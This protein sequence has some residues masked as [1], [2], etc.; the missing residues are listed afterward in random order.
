MEEGFDRYTF[1][2]AELSGKVDYC[3]FGKVTRDFLHGFRQSKHYEVMLSAFLHR[4]FEEPEL[5]SPANLKSLEN[6]LVDRANAILS[7]ERAKDKDRL[8]KGRKPVYELQE[9]EES[10]EEEPVLTEEELRRQEEERLERELR[11]EERL[12]ARE[13]ERRRNEEAL[14]ARARQVDTKAMEE[15][16][17]NAVVLNPGHLKPKTGGK[18]QQQKK[19]VTEDELREMESQVAALMKEKERLQTVLETSEEELPAKLTE[20][21]EQLAAVQAKPKSQDGATTSKK[22]PMQPKQINA[23]AAELKQKL[24]KLT[25]ERTR[26][27]LQMKAEPHPLR[28]ELLS[29][30]QTRDEAQLKLEQA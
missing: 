21:K 24:S 18:Q 19:Q 20:A 23:R 27:A 7:E 26:L 9:S 30:L 22:A 8:A 5:V 1:Q 10:E 4:L 14:R 13:E 3:A 25:V 11:E 16:L 2:F 12:A 17:Q 15:M 6:A 28:E 29:V